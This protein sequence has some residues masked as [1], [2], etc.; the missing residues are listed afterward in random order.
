MHLSQTFNNSS[1]K[2]QRTAVFL[3]FGIVLVLGLLLFKDYGMSIDERVDH[4][5]GLVNARYVLEKIAPGY[6]A[7]HPGLSVLP[8]LTTYPD[9]HYGPFFQLP[10]AIIPQILGF[11]DSREIFFTRHLLTFLFFFS[12][13]AAFYGILR[14]RFRNSWWAL[15]GCLFLV[16]SP[17]IFAESFYNGKDIVFLSVM[18]W[19]WFS[20]NNFRQKLNLK[21][22]FLHAIICG[23]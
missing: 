23:A 4:L 21:W 10:A 3:F 20:L 19:G 15:T 11:N 13:L 12:G 17:R 18:L 1:Q 22:L 5:T 16:L 14:Q 9:R 6:V 8:K 2:F 7:T